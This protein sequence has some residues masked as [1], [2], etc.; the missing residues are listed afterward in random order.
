M[1]TS[2][3]IKVTH[4]GV[5]ITYNEREDKWQFTL[6]GRDRSADSLAKAKEYIDKPI[7]A[8]KAKPFAKIP[9]WLYS[10][11]AEEPVKVEVTGIAEINYGC[12]SVWINNSGV[13]SKERVHNIYQRNDK[14]DMLIGQI[15]SKLQQV[16]SLREEISDI[17]S[18]LGQLII[19]KEE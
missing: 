13:R 9:A 17:K 2:Q 1:N 19:S 3:Q 7:P 5:T 15:I 10:Y 16:G 8:E 14:N 11:N 12:Q 6:R 18:M 4:S